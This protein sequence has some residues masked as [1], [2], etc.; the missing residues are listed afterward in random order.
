MFFFVTLGFVENH[1]SARLTSSFWVVDSCSDKV[2]SYFLEEAQEEQR[3]ILYHLGVFSDR[4]H[5]SMVSSIMLNLSLC[6][7]RLF[8]SDL[9]H[10]C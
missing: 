3:E 10:L 1:S 6:V 9:F 8:V 7:P 4:L 5:L 2:S